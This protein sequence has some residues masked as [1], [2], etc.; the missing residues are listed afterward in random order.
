MT[1]IRTDE[2][3]VAITDLP[4]ASPSDPLEALSWLGDTVEEIAE[5]LRA[6][7]IK[8]RLKEGKQCV[9]ARYLRIWWP[10][11]E[12]LVACGTS[13]VDEGSTP[14]K[15]LNPESVKAFEN[16]FDNGAFPDLI[17]NG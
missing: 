16:L 2:V 11:A 7:G 4:D 8:G 6:R 17:D 3:K 1:D 14:R 13:W 15:Y 9:L 12:T 5:G 10:G